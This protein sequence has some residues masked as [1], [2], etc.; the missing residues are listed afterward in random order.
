[1]PT[2]ARAYGIT[3][4]ELHQRLLVDRTLHVDRDG[5]LHY[6]E[7]APTS[8]AGPQLIQ[9]LVP[10]PDTFTLHS[11]PGAS[12][13]IY[14]DFNGHVLTG[15]AWNTGLADPINA[16]A[17]T[18]D[19]DATTFNDSER[20]SIQYIWQR[21]AEDFAPFDVDVTTEL[22][23]E[24]ILTRSSSSDSVY[25]VRVLISAIS[26]AVFGHGSPATARI[27]SRAGCNR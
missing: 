10:L 3:A 13:T 16:P 6:V 9:A 7:P 17:W 24:T 1:M 12:K 5:R 11:K 20:T 4:T 2:V 14:L 8:I 21:V 26:S 19:A 15:T 22:T 18:T 23:S 25:G 27:V